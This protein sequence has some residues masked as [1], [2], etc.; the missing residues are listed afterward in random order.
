MDVASV[1]PIAAQIAEEERRRRNPS[2]LG[3]PASTSVPG[4]VSPL[5]PVGQPGPVIGSAPTPLAPRPGPVDSIAQGMREDETDLAARKASA[6]KF[7]NAHASLTP[8]TQAEVLRLSFATGAPA[9]TIAGDLDAYRKQAEADSIDWGQLQQKHPKVAEWLLDPVN[10][11]LAKDAIH[12]VQGLAWW[13]GRWAAMPSPFPIGGGPAIVPVEFQEGAVHKAWRAGTAMLE[14]SQLAY[15][16]M[17]SGVDADTDPRILAL[18]RF[19]GKD[20]GQEEH[21]L[22]GSVLGLTEFLA[23]LITGWGYG[24][25]MGAAAGGAVAAAELTAAAPTGGL[26]LLGLPV[27][28][29]AATVAGTIA[30]MA[31]QMYEMD[32]GLS[33]RALLRAQKERGV[34]VDPG[35]ARRW[36]APMG[37]ANALLTVLPAAAWVKHFPLLRALTGGAGEATAAS[38][39]KGPPGILLGGARAAGAAALTTGTQAATMG[40]Q[41]VVRGAGREAMVEAA[42]GP[43]YWGQIPGEA[44]AAFAGGV[45]SFWLL[46][47]SGFAQDLADNALALRRASHAKIQLEAIARHAAATRLGPAAPEK[48]QE[49]VRKNL[50]GEATGADQLHVFTPAETL[51]SFAQEH[52]VP[53]QD[54]SLELTGDPRAIQT[55]QDGGHD[56]A[57]PIDRWAARVAPSPHHAELLLGS[58]PSPGEPTFRVIAEDAERLARI[59]ADL[60]QRQSA[61]PDAPEKLGEAERAVYDDVY[62]KA[63]AVV[64]EVEAE[65]WALVVAGR[66]GAIAD[67]WNREAEAPEGG[68]TALDFYRRFAVT[69]SRA[70]VEAQALPTRAGETPVVLGQPAVL[71]GT[72]GAAGATVPEAAATARPTRF[73]ELRSRLARFWRVL[74]PQEGAAG[75]AGFEGELL[76]ALRDRSRGPATAAEPP[77]QPGTALRIP[78]R[79]TAGLA[80]E[81]IAWVRRQAAVPWFEARPAL[82][83]DP[84]AAPGVL[85]R[86]REA[87]APEVLQ[88]VEA[89]LRKALGPSAGF[90]RLSDRELVLVNVRNDEGR[91]LLGT[92]ARFLAAMDRLAATH[93]AEG[94][95]FGTESGHAE[96]PADADVAALAAGSPGRPDLLAWLRGWRDRVDAET[97]GARLEEPEPPEPLEP[98]GRLSAAERVAADESTAREG[99]KA[100]ADAGEQLPV[101]GLAEGRGAFPRLA[102]NGARELARRWGASFRAAGWVDFTKEKLRS[103]SSSRGSRGSTRTR[104]SRP[105]GSSGSSATEPATGS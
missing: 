83:G 14:Q 65:T 51:V 13:T 42:G 15:R 68:P 85:L 34:P 90:T 103:C 36:A 18:D 16:D 73:Q 91:G 29:P 20:Y 94:V 76:G 46:S 80:A 43:T 101:S 54:L 60:A 35:S 9:E 55:A 99:E 31:W 63:I 58:R 84:A 33:Y 26:A 64:D 62:R 3:L 105:R 40:A 78:D 5:A 97:R 32:A 11:T 10:A 72:V 82:L 41:Q 52:K 104:A 8:E 96:R 6:L 12:D 44:W 39:L 70:G 53:L 61:L 49:L 22:G 50:E 69:V 4:A 98:A 24:L 45:E 93:D 25:E 2:A 37:F 66:F 89:D 48:L 79:R 92:D 19:L 47:L 86:F 30:G 100:V 87:L 71:A 59:V 1:D 67:V 56:V 38:V 81:M 77:L 23:P 75:G 95:Y 28:V 7:L 17:L 57:I 102:P 21:F 74:R 27:T 88:A